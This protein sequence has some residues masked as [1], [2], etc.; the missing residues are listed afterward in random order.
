MKSYST[1]EKGR[2]CMM[3]F[4]AQMTRSAILIDQ[5]WGNGVSGDPHVKHIAS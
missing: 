5:Y 3:Q 2:G 4:L 1:V